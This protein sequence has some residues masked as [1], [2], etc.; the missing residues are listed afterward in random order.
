MA[1]R[2]RNLLIFLVRRQEIGNSYIESTKAVLFTNLLCYDK[3]T[4]H[5]DGNPNK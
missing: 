3:W 4:S 5:M 2:E 1:T